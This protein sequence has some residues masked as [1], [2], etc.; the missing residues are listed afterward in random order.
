MFNLNLIE[1]NLNLIYN[2]TVFEYMNGIIF[3]LKRK[4]RQKSIK[5]EKVKKNMFNGSNFDRKDQADKSA[6]LG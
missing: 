5:R 6:L 1:F 4:H 3:Q 2:S